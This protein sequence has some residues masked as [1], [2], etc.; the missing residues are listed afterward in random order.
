MRPL[1]SFTLVMEALVIC[2]A[3]LV[4]MRLT[5]VGGGTIWAVAGP[6]AGLCVLLCGVLSRRWAVPVGWAVQAGL[7][8]SGLVVPMMYVLGAVFAVIWFCSVRFGRRVDE[9]KAARAAAAE[10]APAAS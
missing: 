3:A 1:C 6:A 8:V 2:F 5:D 4:A 7:V 9:L 10:S